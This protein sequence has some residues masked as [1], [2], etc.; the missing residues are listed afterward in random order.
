MDDK[1]T[2][3]PISVDVSTILRECS[4]PVN[5]INIDSV[6]G[7]NI[8]ISYANVNTVSGDKVVIGP[9]CNVRRVEYRESIELS[10]DAKVE[11][12]VKLS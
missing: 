12:V 10:Q 9:K 1:F 7:D 11:E 6:E 5:S 8:V 3:I 2:D 4:M